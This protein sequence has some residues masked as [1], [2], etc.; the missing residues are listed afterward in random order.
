MASNGNLASSAMNTQHDNGS[1]D[2]F[3]RLRTVGTGSF[4]RVI[5][6]KFKP[7]GQ[8][9]ALKV[10]EKERV[11]KMKQVEHT[12]AE[13]AILSAISFPFIVDLITSFKDNA[14]LYMASEYIPGGELFSHLRAAGRYTEAHALFYTA[15]IVL[16]FEYLHQHDIMY[17]DL[18][19]ENLLFAADG[20]LKLTDFGFAKVVKD[21][22][23]TMCGTPEY[24]AP[25]ILYM[26]G[27]N[28]SVDWWA[29][30]ILVYEMTA[31]F[32]P[33]YADT[34]MDIYQKILAC[35]LKFPSH[36]SKELRELL[37]S[38]LTNDITRRLGCSIRGPQEIKEH[39]WL[40]TVAWE[41]L[42]ARQ[43]QAPHVPH[44]QD[45]FDSSH[46]DDYDELDIAYA[47]EELHADVFAAF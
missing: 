13:K 46:Y 41:Q 2:D 17:R 15:Q 43:I 21:K 23:W 42:L 37:K 26:R 36:V 31:G 10:L 29:L 32:P 44:I 5:L 7:T 6:C 8:P 24:L 33:F 16:C 9:V 39:R 30:G 4:G 3:D 18:K 35:K 28:K 27:Y 12:I 11:I 45:T 1:F 14:N 40:S 20:Y 47:D 19:P 25:E 38:L 34:P 22:T